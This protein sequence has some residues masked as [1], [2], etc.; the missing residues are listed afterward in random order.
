MTM[1][2]VAKGLRRG[3]VALIGVYR[4]STPGEKRWDELSVESVITPYD[5]FSPRAAK[6]RGLS[7]GRRHNLGVNSFAK[8]TV[9]TSNYPYDAYDVYELS[10]CR[11][12]VMRLRTLRMHRTLVFNFAP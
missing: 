3:A 9:A 11:P 7:E 4:L 6:C 12:F 1:V 10:Y 2:T 8:N 5:T